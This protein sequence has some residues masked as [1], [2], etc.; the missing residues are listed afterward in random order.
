MM[1][2]IF[3]TV[4]FGW[5]VCSLLLTP[6]LVH[7]NPLKMRRP[8]L[9]ILQLFCVWVAAILWLIALFSV[10]FNTPG[11]AKRVDSWICNLAYYRFSQ[12]DDA[13]VTNEGHPDDFFDTV[14][15]QAQR[16]AEKMAK[17]K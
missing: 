13:M 2:V 14:L 11:V 9:L 7:L 10:L 8:Y 5:L 3:V 16:D 1:Y 17:G 6:L 15:K 12:Y 4:L